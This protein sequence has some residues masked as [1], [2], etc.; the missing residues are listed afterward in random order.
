MIKYEVRVHENGSREWY[1][2]GQRH[3]EDGPAVEWASG[4]RYWYFNGEIH[5]E[6]GPAIEQANGDR[7]WC[8][9]GRLYREDGPA[10]EWADGSCGWYLNDKKVTEQEVMKTTKE[11]T[12]AEIERLLGHKVK[13]V[14]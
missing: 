4:N 8:L 10:I 11:L 14:K 6:D 7:Y 2:N 13:I 12:V 5:R 3:R 1:L 9:N